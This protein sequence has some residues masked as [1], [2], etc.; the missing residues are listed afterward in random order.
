MAIASNRKVSASV[1]DR[2]RVLMA[3]AQDKNASAEILAAIAK[4]FKGQ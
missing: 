3:I 2:E 4:S 1:L